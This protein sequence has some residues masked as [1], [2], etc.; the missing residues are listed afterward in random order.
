[1]ITPSAYSSSTLSGNGGGM[2]DKEVIFYCGSGYRSALT[3]MYAH[4]MGYE[5]VRNFSDGWEGW[6]T[7]YRK[8]DRC[9]D[10]ITKGWCQDPSGR[11]IET[12]AK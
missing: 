10:S 11:P 3:F 6:S 2:F 9:T 4:L 1:E 8:D 5:N 12:G 7:T